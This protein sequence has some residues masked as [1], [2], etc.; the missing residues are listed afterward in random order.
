[1]KKIVLRGLKRDALETGSRQAAGDAKL[2]FKAGYQISATRAVGEVHELALEKD[3]LLEFIFDDDTTWFG[4]TDSLY[5]VF[6]E[7]AGRKRSAGEAFELPIYLDSGDNKR[8]FIGDIA[9]KILNVFTKKAVTRK[10]KDIAIGLEKKLLQ[11]RS[12]LYSVNG[13]FQLSKTTPKKIR[14]ALFTFY[15][16]YQFL[17]RWWFWR[18]IPFGTVELYGE[19]LCRQYPG[20]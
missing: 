5:H 10:V 8:G 16:W 7:A 4:G 3:D 17:Y 12:G 14:P 2:E 9:L 18:C 11:G 20:F 13:S 1:M 19:Y 6:P 15:P